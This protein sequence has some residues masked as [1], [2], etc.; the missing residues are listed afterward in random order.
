[1]SQARPAAGD[2]P[3][4]GDQP[5]SGGLFQGL[6]ELTAGQVAE[7]LALTP[8]P[9][10]G[11]YRETY[12][13][14]WTVE[15]EQGLRSLS[16]VIH[17]LLTA[18]QPSRLHRLRFDEVWLYNAGAAVE[19]VL[20]GGRVAVASSP[21]RLEVLGLDSPQ[22]VVSG[23]T[24]MGARVISEGQAD[25]GGGRAPERRW[26]ADRRSSPELQWT[27]VSCVVTPGFHFDDFELGE[28]EALLRS[29]PQA[30]RVIQALT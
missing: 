1:M 24:W 18:D 12:R 2:Q 26:T 5:A 8:H 3:P 29:F 27:L 7:R 30:R 20:L 19:M 28:R 9:E 16:T 21:L 14:P 6:D 25:W 22:V 23:G 13:S 10:G 15:T 11:Y 4:C 17:Y